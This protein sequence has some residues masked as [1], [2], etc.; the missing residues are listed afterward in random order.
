MAC[1]KFRPRP[2]SQIIQSLSLLSLI[3]FSARSNLSR[4][5]KERLLLLWSTGTVLGGV[6][7]W[8][9]SIK[10]GLACTGVS[11]S[12]KRRKRHKSNYLPGR[13][14]G[15]GAPDQIKAS[16]NNPGAR[17]TCACCMYFKPKT[18]AWR[19]FSKLRN[20]AVFSIQTR[21]L[22]PI[23][24]TTIWSA[25]PIYI[26]IT[27]HLQHNC[28]RRNFGNLFTYIW[29][30]WHEEKECKILGCLNFCSRRKLWMESP[31]AL[32]QGKLAH[33]K[34]ICVCQ[35]PIQ[36]KTICMESWS[37]DRWSKPKSSSPSTIF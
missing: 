29:W 24:T 10:Q 8:P 21:L 1:F 35:T 26:N 33:D 37:H 19:S 20:V 22:I 36:R 34:D 12:I 18:W 6:A 31:V 11:G 5:P 14:P 16:Q 4:R 30:H 17:W 32:V 3:R 15:R 13:E 7:Y 9:E 27:E 2:A 23:T 28:L 25:S